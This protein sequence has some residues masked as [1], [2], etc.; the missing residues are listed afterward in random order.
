MREGRIDVR[1]IDIVITPCTLAFAFPKHIWFDSG[2]VLPTSGANISD[3]I[4]DHSA[5]RTI[6]EHVRRRCP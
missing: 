4:K 3:G 5:F 6:G 1:I 2:C